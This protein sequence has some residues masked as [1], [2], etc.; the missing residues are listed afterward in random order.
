SLESRVESV[1]SR[2]ESVE[3]RLKNVE[4]RLGSLE[5][6][7]EDRL[8][9]TRP[10]WELVQAQLQDLRESHERLRAEMEKGFRIIDRRLEIQPIELSRVYGYQRD[11]EERVEKIEKRMK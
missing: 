2:V 5:T 8:K 7:V 9:E 1:E 3:S 4:E 10:M 6:K 11:L